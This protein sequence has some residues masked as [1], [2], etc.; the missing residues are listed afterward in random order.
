MEFD[1]T[2]EVSKR[3]HYVETDIF[4]RAKDGNKWGSFNIGQLDS[5]SLLRFLRSRGGCNEFAENCVG[6]MLGHGHLT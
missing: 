6:V 3:T 2:I 5:V 4:V 1:L